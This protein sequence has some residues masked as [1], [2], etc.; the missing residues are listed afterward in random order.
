MRKLNRML[1]ILACCTAVAAVVQSG[2]ASD[3]GQDPS[4]ANPEPLP[5]RSTP[6]PP[7]QSTSPQRFILIPDRHVFHNSLLPIAIDTTPRVFIRTYDPDVGS[8]VDTEIPDSTC[9]MSCRG[10]QAQSGR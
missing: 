1:P 4:Y 7:Y 10:P 3:Y 6:P 5:F 8:Y 2:T 9:V